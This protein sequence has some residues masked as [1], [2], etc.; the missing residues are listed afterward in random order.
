MAKRVRDDNKDS[1]NS[2]NKVYV[3][4]N[5][6]ICPITREIFNRPVIANDGFTYEEWAINKCINNDN[7]E[8]NISPLTREP[9]NSYQENKFIKGLVTR[10]LELKPELKEEQFSPDVYND[11]LQNRDY[12]VKLL[13]NKRFS[14]LEN[15]KDIRL[16]DLTDNGYLIEFL[17]KKCRDT[18][19]FKKILTNAFDLNCKNKERFTPMYYIMMN[20]KKDIIITAM[21]LGAEIHNLCLLNYIEILDKNTIISSE[22]QEEII[23][24]TID[25]NLI[26][27]AFI[28]K[29]RILLNF[30]DDSI[31]FNNIIDKIVTIEAGIHKLIDIS[32][33]VDY[34]NCDLSSDRLLYI[35]SKV[36]HTKFDINK[37]CEYYKINS[38]D[39]H[40]NQRIYDIY[41]GI[42]DRTDLNIDEQ[43]LL[44]K[45]FK[46]L[47][48]SINIDG[49]DNYLINDKI[50][51][52][53]EEMMKGKNE[54]TELY[55]EFINK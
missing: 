42:I 45:S 47:F 25:N 15:I 21:N 26:V 41:D 23:K 43:K 9:L 31:I 38:S 24:Y 12:C 6:L 1:N 32:T 18:E 28:D 51:S 36:L 37:L 10:L 16:L 50:R 53:I 19:I 54:A 17:S 11:Y 4:D 14:E 30:E 55:N 33:L 48:E 29:P 44:L 20:C 5:E 39:L 35:L 52:Q 40:L 3:S 27:M 2:P 34:I 13:I 46:L 7:E 8:L 22:D 49:I